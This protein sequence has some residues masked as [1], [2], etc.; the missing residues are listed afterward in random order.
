[1]SHSFVEPPRQDLQVFLDGLIILGFF[2]MQRVHLLEGMWHHSQVF[3][4]L[5]VC[6]IGVLYL[7]Q[8]PIEHLYC[9][10]VWVPSIIK[11]H[12][13]FS[14][15]CALGIHAMRLAKVFIQN[16][17]KL[18]VEIYQTIFYHKKICNEICLTKEHN[19]DSK[20]NIISQQVFGIIQWYQS[21]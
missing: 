6:F 11:F 13:V 15:S 19:L 1:M 8:N 20:H 16:A 14:I 4:L 18:F 7:P 2:F 5:I 21:W 12:Y 9:Y 17:C 3:D 10:F